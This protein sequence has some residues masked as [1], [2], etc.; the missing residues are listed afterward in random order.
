MWLSK[1]P[2]L[3]SR[4]TR[5]DEISPLLLNF[6]SLWQILTVYFLFGKMLSLLWKI[7]CIIGLIFIVANG[8]ILKIINP[9]GHTGRVLSSKNHF[10]SRCV[11]QK[12]ILLKEFKWKWRRGLNVNLM[13][14]TYYNL[15][16]QKGSHQRIYDGSGSSFVKG[17]EQLDCPNSQTC[18]EYCHACSA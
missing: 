10:F 14:L 16:K 7:W 12:E 15:T 4:V 5:F 8:Q 18:I 3:I 9:S 6:T 11:L 2:C 1:P 13:H 17:D